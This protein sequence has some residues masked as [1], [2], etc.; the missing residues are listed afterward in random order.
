MADSGAYRE[1]RD[2]LI[3]KIGLFVSAGLMAADETNITPGAGDIPGANNTEQGYAVYHLTDT[4]AAEAPIYLRFG[5]GRGNGVSQARLTV[6]VGTGTDGSGGLQGDALTSNRSMIPNI[7]LAGDTPRQSYMCCNDGF[8]G[9]LWKAGVINGSFFVC[10]TC[11]ADG[12]PNAVGAMVHWGIGSDAAITGRQALRFADPT[13]A[14]TAQTELATAAL[15]FSPQA[16]ISSAIGGDIQVFLAW[17]IIPQAVPLFGVCGVY[18]TE[19]NQGNTLQATLVGAAQRTYLSWG[20]GVAPFGPLS[21]SATG[22][23]SIAMLWE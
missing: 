12:T 17:T 18:G 8:F 21:S 7:N 10:R 23:P 19:V 4:N 15:G 20:T 14:Y 13:T 2:E 11:D 3:T 16:P 5:F 6:Q 22:G 9:L 1:W